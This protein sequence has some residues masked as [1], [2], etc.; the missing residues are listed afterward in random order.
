MSSY[1]KKYKGISLFDRRIIYRPY[2]F[3][4]ESRHISMIFRDKNLSDMISFSYNSWNQNDAAWDLMGHMNRISEN[5]R[6]DTDRGL[7]TIVMDGEN[8]W[9]YYANNGREFFETIYANIDRQGALYSTTISD[10]LDIEP[11]KRSI[12]NVFP[13]SW[14]NHNFEIWIGE[15]QDNLSW[16]YLGKVRKDLMKFTK[17]LHKEGDLDG[18]RIRQAWRE[19]HI[20][21]GS[22]WNWWYSGEVRRGADNPF[23]KLYLT[24]LKN[25]YKLLNKPIPGFL[26]I[27]IA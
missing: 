27:S 17:E 18:S 21:E 20:A 16:D 10:F 24:H 6:R 5:L 1:D 4:R 12:S 11:P 2:N 23:D 14:I 26:K 7:V 19:L 25:I 15:E 8:A 9:E 3:K 13:G 22:D